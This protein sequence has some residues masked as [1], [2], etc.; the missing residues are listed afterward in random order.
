MDKR[1]GIFIVNEK[2]IIIFYTGELHEVPSIAFSP[3]TIENQSLLK[4]FNKEIIVKLAKK[5]TSGHFV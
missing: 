3:D 1:S 4:V 5:D 2:G